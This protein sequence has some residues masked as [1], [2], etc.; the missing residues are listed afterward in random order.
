MIKLI[1]WKPGKTIPRVGYYHENA[2]GSIRIGRSTENELIIMDG[3]VSRFHAYVKHG[4]RGLTI[5]DLSST[6]GTYLKRADSTIQ[7]GTAPLVNGDKI[8]ISEYIIELYLDS[9]SETPHAATLTK[10][11]IDDAPS[12]TDPNYSITEKPYQSQQST[13]MLSPTIHSLRQLIGLILTTDP[14]LDAFC[15]DNFSSV[16]KLFTSSMDRVSKINIL[17]E[18]EQP[19]IIAMYLRESHSEQYE[20]HKK[21]LQYSSRSGSIVPSDLSFRKF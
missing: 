4:E 13:P 20:L 2:V 9:D 16:K 17:L 3:R 11:M 21:I 6:N 1:I 14:E 5:V 10:L 7:V 18:K 19:H 8:I 12:S 15:L